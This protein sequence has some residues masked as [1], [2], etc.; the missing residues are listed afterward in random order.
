MQEFV[1]DIP[2]D[3]WWTQNRRGH[4]RVKFAHTSAVK[5]RAMAFARFWLQNGHHRPQHFPVH[6]TAVIHPLTHGRFDPENAAPMVK[7]ILDALTDTGF[8]PDDD[9][10]SI[11]SAPTIAAESQAAE[12]AGIE[13]QSES[14]KRSTD[15]ATNVTEK[16]KT[17]QEIIDWCEQLE[18]DGLRLAN[19]LL[20]QRD[21]TAY[22]VVKGQIDAYGKTA[23]HCRSMLGYSGSMPSE[24]PN[25]I[26]D[27]K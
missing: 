3:E 2:R 7:A 21:M 19:A 22:G 24:V 9:S 1:V 11:S 5:Q 12:K 14:K 26:E 6:V 23:D 25:Q 20:M 10:Q 15:M 8:W 27:A 13:S 4:W 18:I 16:D 17:L